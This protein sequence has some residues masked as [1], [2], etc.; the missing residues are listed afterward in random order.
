MVFKPI[1][2]FFHSMGKVIDASGF[3]VITSNVR[4]TNYSESN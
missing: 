3:P 4:Y 1:I 2:D